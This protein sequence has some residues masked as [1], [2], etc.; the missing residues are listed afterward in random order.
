MFAKTRALG[1]PRSL[2]VTFV[3]SNLNLK[4]NEA[5]GASLNS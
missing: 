2:M 4:K 5:K 3:K 1:L